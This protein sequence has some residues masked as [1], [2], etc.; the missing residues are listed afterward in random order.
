MNLSWTC[1]IC[2]KER[3]DEKIS[4][5]QKPIKVNDEVIGEQNI[6]YCNDNKECLKGTD[7]FTFLN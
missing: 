7:E 4:V 6:R 2:E 3:P 5:I 1:H